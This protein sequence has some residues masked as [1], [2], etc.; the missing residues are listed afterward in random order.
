MNANFG[1]VPVLEKRIKDK[2]RYETLANRALEYLEKYKK[3][4]NLYKTSLKL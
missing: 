3:H 2:R 1:F 4:Y